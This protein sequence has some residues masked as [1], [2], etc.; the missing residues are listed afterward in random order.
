[1]QLVKDAGHLN[2]QSHNELLHL[3]EIIKEFKQFLSNFISKLERQRTD[4]D[5]IVNLYEFYETVSGL[6][7][8]SYL[9]SISI[10]NAGFLYFIGN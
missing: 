4:M 7:C 2:N 3:E 10:M 5:N 1:M 6:R 9:M 8:S